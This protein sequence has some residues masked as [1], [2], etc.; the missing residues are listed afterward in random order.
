MCESVLDPEPEKKKWGGRKEGKGT[1][2]FFSSLRHYYVIGTTGKNWK[3]VCGFNN[4]IIT[5]VIP[6]FLY[7]YYEYVRKC[8]CFEEMHVEILRDSEAVCL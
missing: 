1:V 2:F 3:E 4:S 6:W 5:M 7:L 8:P